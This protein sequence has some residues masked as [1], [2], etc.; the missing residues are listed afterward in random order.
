[1][2]WF[3][4]LLAV[5][6]V[7]A[8]Q[9]V[10]QSFTAPRTGTS[11]IVEER[12]LSA[13]EIWINLAET[14]HFDVV[15]AGQRSYASGI[16]T[17]SGQFRDSK[18]RIVGHFTIETKS[19]GVFDFATFDPTSSDS[20]LESVLRIQG[21]L[22]FS[23]LRDGHG[24]RSPF[25][26]SR[27]VKL[28]S[29]GKSCL[30][31]YSWHDLSPDRAVGNVRWNAIVTMVSCDPA[32]SQAVMSAIFDQARPVDETT[33]RAI[34]ARRTLQ[35]PPVPLAVLAPATPS[36]IS[37]P[38]APGE[39]FC[40]QGAIVL[41]GP[42]CTPNRFQITKEEYDRRLSASYAGITLPPPPGAAPP[43]GPATPANAPSTTR[44]TSRPPPS[45][46]VQPSG[47]RYCASNDLEVLYATAGVCRPNERSV[48][49][50]EFERLEEERA[51]RMSSP[52]GSA[53]GTV[54]QRLGRLRDMQQRGLIT[55]QEAA[56]RRQEIL[57]DL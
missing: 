17:Q 20:I 54:E 32:F 44:T 42:I 38:A 13:A 4:I 29:D 57:R 45:S 14:S 46:A 31:G 6:L 56:Q 43:A 39:R 11:E 26:K 37:P 52:G 24:F 23:R 49:L 51:K 55:E 33:N 7:A 53:G 21:S 41:R 19:S 27:I 47:R 48:T 10:A 5:L 3:P 36:A 22:E 28:D 15:N 34:L 30:Y 50:A 18:L 2:R 25:S 35:G 16:K 40:I 1:M 9:V 8:P 12:D